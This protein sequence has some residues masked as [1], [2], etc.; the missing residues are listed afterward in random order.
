MEAQDPES[1]DAGGKTGKEVL[2]SSVWRAQGAAKH[3]EA[4]NAA[5]ALFE[6]CVFYIMKSGLVPEWPVRED[7]RETRIIAD[8]L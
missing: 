8:L 3:F 2:D 1:T 6:P 5:G 4:G 7:K